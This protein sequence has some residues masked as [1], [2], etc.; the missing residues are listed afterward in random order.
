MIWPNDLEPMKDGKIIYVDLNVYSI[1]FIQ[2]SAVLLDNYKILLKRI[3][4][5]R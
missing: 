4:T 1:L 2:I 3:I 5:I